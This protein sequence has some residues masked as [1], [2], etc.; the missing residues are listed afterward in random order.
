MHLFLDKNVIDGKFG[1]LYYFLQKNKKKKKINPSCEKK[2]N[3]RS[4]C[5]IDI[6]NEGEIL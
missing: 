6:T 3:L 2:C 5:F 1:F 4:P